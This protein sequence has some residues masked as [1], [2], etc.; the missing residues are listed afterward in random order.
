MERENFK[1]PKHPPNTDES[2]RY[3]AVGVASQKFFAR[4]FEPVI[5][6]ERKNSYSRK[7]KHYEKLTAVTDRPLHIAITEK[8]TGSCE[9]YEKEKR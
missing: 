5:N 9:G 3:L 7:E 1:V 4:L 8:K 2:E 6:R